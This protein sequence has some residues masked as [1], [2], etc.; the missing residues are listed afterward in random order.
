MNKFV[1]MRGG[2]MLNNKFGRNVSI[3]LLFFLFDF[4]NFG[5]TW[6]TKKLKLWA[7]F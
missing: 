2:Y 4:F 7:G 6:Q 3:Q 5:Q 1:L